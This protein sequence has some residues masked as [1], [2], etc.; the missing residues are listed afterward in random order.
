MNLAEE[1]TV[2]LVKMEVIN[3]EDKAL[4]SYGFK[5]GFLLFLNMITVII[6]GVIFNMIWQSVIF[7]IAYSCL[8]VYAGGYHANTEL[9]CYIFSLIMIIAV[10]WLINRILWNTFICLSITVISDLIILLLA[11]VEDA[12]KPLD[13]KEIEIFKKRTYIILVFSFAH[14]S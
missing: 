9:S 10:L 7:M 13:H 1:L 5:Q 2:K 11:P 14:F 6:I 3:N 4:Y 8:R 12:N